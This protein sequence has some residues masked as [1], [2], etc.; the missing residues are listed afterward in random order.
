MHPIHLPFDKVRSNIKIRN[1]GKTPEIWDVIRQ[2]WVVLQPEEWVRQ[3][4]IHVFSDVYGFS[5][6]LMAIEKGFLI[7]QKPK[8]FD[9]VIFDKQANPFILVECKAFQIPLNQ[10]VFNQMCIYN[11][12]IKSPYLVASNGILTYC[13]KQN[14]ENKDFMYLEDIPSLT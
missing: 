11:D 10:Q 2:K 4:L 7:N 13:Y 1:T 12:H 9:L 8:R 5:K 6:N 3:Q 14:H